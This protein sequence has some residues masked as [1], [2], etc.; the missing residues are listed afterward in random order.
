MFRKKKIVKIILVISL[1]M[2]FVEGSILFLPYIK[3][4]KIV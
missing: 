4:R 1:T 3:Q 2:I